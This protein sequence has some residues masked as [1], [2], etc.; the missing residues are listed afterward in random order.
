MRRGLLTGIVAGVVV[1]AIVGAVLLY[2]LAVPGRL[3]SSYKER[4]EPEHE[5]VE[6]ALEPVFDSFSNRTFGED[7][8]EI[9]KADREGE[10]VR[11][12][13]RVTRRELKEIGP[14]RRAI[15]RAEADLEKIDEDDLTETP[16]WPLLGGRGELEEAE[17]IAGEES[18]YLRKARRFLTGYRK[19]V[20]WASDRLRFYR[21]FGLTLGR[22]FGSIPDNPSSPGQVTR[23]L[24]RTA[25]ETAAQARR[26]RRVKAPPEVRGEHRNIAA[27]VEFVVSEI[28]GLA[29]AVRRADLARINQFDR[30]VTRGL[31]RYD[32]RSTANFRKLISRS[33]YVRQ[34]RDLER[35]QGRIGRAYDAL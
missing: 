3:A 2:L 31:R 20:D 16:D 4:A 25:D 28:R 33:T 1:L 24:D 14:A 29:D 32:R 26:F 27:S 22:G 35:R 8:S 10:Y 21:R 12:L 9:E 15:K 7:T 13:E 34:I 6:D 18:D 11:A 17:E 5:K 19:L 23:P 30:R